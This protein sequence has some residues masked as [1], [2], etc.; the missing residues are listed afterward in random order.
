[1]GNRYNNLWTLKKWVLL[2]I[3]NSPFSCY[4]LNIKHLG[5]RPLRKVVMCAGL[6]LAL[7]SGRAGA[8]EKTPEAKHQ[9]VVGVLKTGA[10]IG[11]T[12][13]PY[14][15]QISGSGVPETRTVL[16][17]GVVDGECKDSKS[18][19][20]EIMY[21]R[22]Q[23]LVKDEDIEVSPGDEAILKAMSPEQMADMKEINIL[24]LKKKWLEEV[25]KAYDEL[26]KLKRQGVVVLEAGIYDVSE[27]TEGTGFTVRILNPSKKVIKYVTID[28]IGLNAVKDPV[29]D[30]RAKATR[31][32]K[33]IGPIGPGEDAG[34]NMEYAWMS[35]LVETFKIT[36]IKID[37]MDGS[38]KTI[39]DPGKV[40]LSRRSYELIEEFNKEEAESANARR[41]VPIP[42]L[43]EAPRASAAPL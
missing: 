10:S 5:G 2:G 13:L 27:Y 12:V 1:M 18:R 24:Y 22:K 19:F 28:F 30:F 32:F 7:V 41:E 37:Y 20:Y 14:T 38:K 42:P 8:E 9:P 29:K 23:Y 34:Y 3:S 43:D 4:R 16:I 6:V 33:A 31:T 21:G 36:S 26:D 17:N 40:R 15:C 25:N 11:T 35:D 39:K